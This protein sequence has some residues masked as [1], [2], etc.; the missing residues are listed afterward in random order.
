MDLVLKI[1]NIDRLKYFQDKM[2]AKSIVID[3]N[4]IIEDHEDFSKAFEKSC[5]KYVENDVKALEEATERMKSEFDATGK[6]VR[7]FMEHKKPVAPLPP[8]VNY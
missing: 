3:V 4:K 1:E 5:E 8:F 2:S 6:D 7:Y